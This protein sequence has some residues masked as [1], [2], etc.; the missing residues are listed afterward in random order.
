VTHYGIG[1]FSEITDISIH[2]LRYYEKEKLICPQ[3]NSSNRRYYTEIDVNRIRFIKRL[4]DMGVPIKEMKKYAIL[5]DAGDSTMVERR[6]LLADFRSVLGQKILRLQA[7]YENLD[8]KIA[9]YEELIEKQ[10]E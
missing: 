4:K 6:N 10:S 9:L 5:R 3:R 2:T 8:A 1:D 7:H